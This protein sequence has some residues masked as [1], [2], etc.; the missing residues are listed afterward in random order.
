M[1]SRLYFKYG[2]MG[3]SK[4]AQA[5]MAKFNYE[6]KGMVVMLVKPSLDNRGDGDGQP[7]VR[8][9]IGLSSPCEIIRPE[10]SFVELF[11]KF[12][13][14]NGCDCVIVDEAQF[15]TTKQ[16]D[17]LKLLTK[18]VPVLCYGLLNNFRCQLF[19]GSKRLVELSDS[20]Q[21][22]KSVCRCGRKSTVNA[23]F[24]N[25]KCVDDGPVVFIGG[26]ESY[27]NM[28]YWCWQDELKK[29]RESD[30]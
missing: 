20:L 13:A 18:Q 14:E 6:Q 25:G 2:T 29:A 17:E 28:C 4:S 7:M 22:I 11:D 27:E 8:S 5:L 15:C 23:R 12:K 1:S 19:E 9:R 30:K 10:D 16:V 3:S 24:I 26:D 21:E